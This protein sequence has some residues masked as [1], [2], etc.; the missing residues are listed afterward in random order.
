MKLKIYTDGGSRGNPGPAGIGVIIKDE[1]G[2][3]LKK[4]SKSVG[5][6]TNNQAEYF[7]IIEA[8]KEAKKLNVSEIDC[9]LDSELLVKQL[10][11]KYKIRDR[12]L[13]LLFIKVWNLIQ[14][15]K[16]VNFYYLPRI[17]NKEADKLVNLALD[18]VRPYKNL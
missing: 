18:K 2:K 15:F 12:K 6:L 9:Y 10:N 1:K 14:N 8:L 3:I 13:S 16:K 5:I 4:I 11:R 7:A 17:K